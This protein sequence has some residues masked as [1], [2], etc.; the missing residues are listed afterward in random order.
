MI[1]EREA[2]LYLRYTKDIPS[3]QTQSY[4]ARLLLRFEIASHLLQDFAIRSRDTLSRN[5]T[6]IR[7]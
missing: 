7:V 5:N 3:S 1:V 2:Q 6:W 4:I